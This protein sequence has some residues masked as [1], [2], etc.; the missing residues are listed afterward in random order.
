[1]Y[2]LI[3]NKQAK[4]SPLALRREGNFEAFLHCVVSFPPRPRVSTDKTAGY[5]ARPALAV[6][7]KSFTVLRVPKQ[8]DSLLSD[9]LNLKRLCSNSPQSE[10]QLKQ[11]SIIAIFIRSRAFR[12]H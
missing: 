10:V 3:R 8:E 2:V 1:M 7:I 9:R 4:L 12:D 6:C 5:L 11:I